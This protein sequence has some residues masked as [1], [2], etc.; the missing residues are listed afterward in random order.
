MTENSKTDDDAPA[1]L[2]AGLGRLE[3]NGVNP[4]DHAI[5]TDTFLTPIYSSL[6]REMQ[7][8]SQPKLRRLK[9]LWGQGCP[10]KWLAPGLVISVAGRNVF[11]PSEALA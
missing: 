6:M 7:Q 9:C 8:A 10:G 4:V 2:P 5:H 11:C 1:H 3:K